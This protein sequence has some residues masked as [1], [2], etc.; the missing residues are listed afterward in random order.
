MTVTALYKTEPL[1]TR[2]AQLERDTAHMRADI[3]DITIDL[4]Q[5]RGKLTEPHTEVNGEFRV[6]RA[7]ISDLGSKTQEEFNA[8]RKEMQ[9]ECKALRTEIH[10][11]SAALRTAMHDG[12]SAV[13][14]DVAE[15]RRKINQHSWVFAAWVV[16]LFA[17]MLR[18]MARG[19]GWMH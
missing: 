5:M 17:T 6:I 12:F 2:V 1:E 18:L 13:R 4:R 14:A 19:V 7:A 9:D 8:I 3:A 16:T 10:E 11:N 15:L